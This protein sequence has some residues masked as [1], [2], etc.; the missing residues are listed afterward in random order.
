MRLEIEVIL[1][2]NIDIYALIKTAAIYIHEISSTIKK[3]IHI[4]FMLEDI[5]EC[6]LIV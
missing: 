6:I 5:P 3:L 1:I 2:D 4:S